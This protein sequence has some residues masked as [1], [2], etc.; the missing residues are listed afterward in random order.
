MH[1]DEAA[2]A[3]SML[4]G[5]SASGWHTCAIMMR[6]ITDG[7]LLNSAFMGG[8]AVT[9]SGGSRPVRPGDVL[10]VR[11]RVREVRE[12][13]TRADAGFVKFLFEVVNADGLCDDRG[14]PPDVRPPC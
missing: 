6:L 11:S 4:G 8:P 3:A 13:R 10:R 1:V 9:R 5:L 12:S 14:R 2:A 7:F